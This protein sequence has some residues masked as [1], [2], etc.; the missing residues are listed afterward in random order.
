MS[1]SKNSSSK[2]LAENTYSQF[3]IENT[4]IIIISMLEVMFLPKCKVN[5]RSDFAFFL[6][7]EDFIPLCIS[8]KKKKKNH[9][10]RTH[11]WKQRTKFSGSLGH[12]E[13]CLTE[14]Q[15][16]TKNVLINIVFCFHSQKVYREKHFKSYSMITIKD[17]L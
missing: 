5:E 3:C 6:N 2:I 13:T 12:A 14:T 10:N 4:S 17:Q 11:K 15:L 7:K 1:L 16:C 9:K 8:P